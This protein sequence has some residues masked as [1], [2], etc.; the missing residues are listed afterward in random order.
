MIRMVRGTVLAYGK[1]FII[2]DVGGPSGGVG[3]KVFVPEPTAMQGGHAS[4]HNLTH[5]SPGA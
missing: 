5:L 2:I 1:D 3:L 4:T